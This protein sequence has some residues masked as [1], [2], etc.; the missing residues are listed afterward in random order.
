MP[1]LPG[2]GVLPEPVIWVP[3]IFGILILLQALATNYEVG[4]MRVIPWE[5]HLMTDYLVGLLL[6]VSPWIFGI[7]EHSQV[8]MIA[9]ALSGI[10]MFVL[11]ALT[12]PEGRPRD[13]VA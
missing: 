2:F 7:A 6:A 11:P 1:N 3:R 8:A 10:F 13:V 9:L 12:H 4:M 5:M